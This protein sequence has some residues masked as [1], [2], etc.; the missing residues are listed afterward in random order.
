MSNVRHPKMR[1]AHSYLVLATHFLRLAESAARQLCKSKNALTVVSG[2]PISPDEYAKKTRWSDHALGV[3]VLFNFY[4]GIE[5]TLKG[6]LLLDGTRKTG[7]KLTPLLAEFEKRH[8]ETEL[9][10]TLAAHIRG[11][12]SSS[13]LGKFLVH[14]NVTIDSWYQSLKYPK[15]TDGSTFSHWALQYGGKSTLK[16]WRGIKTGAVNIRKS[17][18]AFVPPPTGA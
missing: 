8:K 18:V 15:A 17:A 14:N 11:I 7:H 13:P 2:G 10:Q 9:A 4:H 6:C 1:E 3:A 5:L 12:D 16:F